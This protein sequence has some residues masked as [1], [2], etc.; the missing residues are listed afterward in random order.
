MTVMLVIKTLA[1]A[2]S[3]GA[4]LSMTDGT[5]RI[6]SRIASLARRRTDR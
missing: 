6:P 2:V 5:R 1:A 4:I 3:I